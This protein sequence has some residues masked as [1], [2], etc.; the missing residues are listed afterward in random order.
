MDFKDHILQFSAR[1]EKLC[2]QIHTEE[3]TKNAL[4]M[5][6]IQLLGYDVFNPF[7]VNPEFIADIGIKKGE[8]VDYA[9]M[10]DGKAI[11]LIECKH[12]VQDLDP[13]NS[14]L[15]RYF[16][17]TDAKF[18]LLTNGVNYRFYTDLVT[19]N[20]MDDT[21]FFEF[22]ITDIKDNEITELR[23]FHKSYFN[24]EN[25]T[26]TASELK[27]LHQIKQILSYEFNEPSDEFVKYFTK[28]VYPGTVTQRVLEQFKI[29]TKK[30]GTLYISDILNERFKTALE[31]EHKKE[32]PLTSA[33]EIINSG[34]E[35]PEP[36]QDEVIACLIIKSILSEKIDAKRV[37][38]R[39]SQSYCAVLLDDTNRKPLCRLYFTDKKKTIG[40][41]DNNK[42]FI[43]TDINDLN[44]LY[45]LKKE[46]FEALYLYK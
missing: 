28:K 42:S 21:P 8:K 27:Y 25:I 38:L 1:V 23:K 36:T 17:T 5:P 46:F 12:H 33:P 20:R 22:K 43:K 7:E 24:I 18:G 19:P 41:I 45:R 14:Q 44:E 37:D 32:E 11:L 16:H 40:I 2:T 3:A 29:I 15:F 13:H 6:F 9:I 4:I 34:A 35:Q 26:N 39:E 31:V 30:A 10:N